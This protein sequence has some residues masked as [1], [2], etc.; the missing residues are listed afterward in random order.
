M[1]GT[2]QYIKNTYTQ[3]QKNHC[4]KKHQ[5]FKNEN[6]ACPQNDLN[7]YSKQVCLMKIIS[8]LS[9]VKKTQHTLILKSII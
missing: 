3:M 4:G 5:T 2:V 7:N 6:I 1:Q 9:A 8:I